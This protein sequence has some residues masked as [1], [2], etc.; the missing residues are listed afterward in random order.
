MIR[1]QKRKL[2][3]IKL[4][5]RTKISKLRNL[6]HNIVNIMEKWSVRQPA[7]HP[8]TNVMTIP[9]KILNVSQI[10]PPLCLYITTLENSQTSVSYSTNQLRYTACLTWKFWKLTR[11][12]W[13]CIDETFL[14]L[15]DEYI[16]NKWQK[17]QIA[18]NEFAGAFVPKIMFGWF[19]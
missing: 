8:S 16:W 2:L 13:D 1:D 9:D 10:D 4:Q 14:K 15:F 17:N 7:L 11:R 5:T 18:T 12:F 19:D 3:T 6:N